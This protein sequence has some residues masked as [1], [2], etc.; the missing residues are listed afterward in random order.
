MGR[1]PRLRLLVD[2][3]CSRDLTNAFAPFALPDSPQRAD[4]DS[5]FVAFVRAHTVFGACRTLRTLPG[6]VPCCCPIVIVVV[7]GGA[8]LL[9]AQLAVP[10]FTVPGSA[11]PRTLH[12]A[13]NIVL[14][15]TLLPLPPYLRL[16]CHHARLL[17]ACYCLL[18][19]VMP[20]TA[21]LPSNCRRPPHHLGYPT[22][23]TL[24]YFCAF[25]FGYAAL[26]F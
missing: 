2:G 10:G 7:D 13:P 3:I 16:C 14:H 23:D 19:L 11:V 6:A 5:S 18:R 12:S 25:C 26:P 17:P 8:V 9:P 24:P 15:Q 20:L 1:L 21:H 22:H 4:V